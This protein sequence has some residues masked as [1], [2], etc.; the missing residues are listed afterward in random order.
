MNINGHIFIL[1][2]HGDDNAKGPEDEESRLT[3]EGICQTE[4]VAKSLRETKIS[5]VYASP[6]LRIIETAKIICE[7]LETK[8]T[9]VPD[10]R[11]CYRNENSTIEEFIEG[12][13]N[14]LV[15]ISS[16]KDLRTER[17]VRLDW[18]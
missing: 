15:K 6:L 1:L 10:W 2:R 14:A 4:R 18:L 5:A 7:T 8:K 9:I 3:E 17:T 13:N 16:Y 12:Y 11:L